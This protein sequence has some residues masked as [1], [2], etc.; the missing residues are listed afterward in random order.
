MKKKLQTNKQHNI[1]K[2]VTFLLAA[3]LVFGVANIAKA[4]KPEGDKK[5]A[6][7]GLN[8]N[9]PTH[10]MIALAGPSSTDID[11]EAEAAEVAGDKVTFAQTNETALWLNYS[12][13]VRSGKSNSISAEISDVPDGLSIKV[14]VSSAAASGKKGETGEGSTK[15]LTTGGVEVVDGIG[16][17]YTGS[18]ENK[19]HSLVYTVS[20]K[21]ESY[22]DLVADN[23]NLTVTYTITEN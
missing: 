5:S 11:F 2:K 12:S 15:E 21:D 14:A 18:G 16:T 22:E 10:A 1:M 20:A 3:L 17:C 7:H 4:A 6:A 9:I 19:G 8:I 23:H 13:I